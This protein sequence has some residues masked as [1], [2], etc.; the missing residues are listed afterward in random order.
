MKIVHLNTSDIM[1]GAAKAAYRLHNAMRS[2]GI[3]SSMLVQNKCGVG[4]MDIQ[5]ISK[6]DDKLFSKFRSIINQRLAPSIVAEYGLFSTAIIGA[7]PSRHHLIESADIIYLHWVNGNFLSLNSLSKLLRLNKRIYWFLHDMWP[8]TGGCHHS[9]ECLKFQSTCSQC[10]MLSVPAK[11]DASFRQF[12]L[13]EKI[14][15]GSKELEFVAPSKWLVDNAKRSNLTRGREV[16]HIPNLID[17]EVFKP[18]DSKFARQVLNLP[19]NS[20]IILFGADSGTKNPYKGWKFLKEALFNIKYS[21][22]LCLVIFGSEYDDQISNEL[23]YPVRFLGRLTD[24]YSLVL[25]YNAAD[26]FVTPSIADNF[27]NTVLESL[28]CGTPVVGFQTGGLPDLITEAEGYLAKYKDCIDLAKGI[29]HC[30]WVDPTRKRQCARLKS[31]KYGAS[32]IL[33]R[34]VAMWSVP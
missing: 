14:Y 17:T 26:V 18:I 11:R 24:E 23:P 10:Q 13:K 2:S 29:D 25:T 19:M 33:S 6:L 31:S 30:L 7:D 5:S 15:A 32:C 9:F 16:H 28:A 4:L 21:D 12:T 27:P 3:D 20:K 1:G 34:H 22:N 8:I